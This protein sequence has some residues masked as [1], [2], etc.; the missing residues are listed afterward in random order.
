M[1]SSVITNITISNRC[2]FPEDKKIISLS[3][4]ASLLA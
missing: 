4:D 3:D 2:Y 1:G